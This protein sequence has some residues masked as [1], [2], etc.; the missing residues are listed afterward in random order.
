MSI[1]LNS[2]PSNIQKTY[3]SEALVHPYNT[4]VF[5]DYDTAVE[6]LMYKVLVPGEIAFAYYNDEACEYGINAIFAVG[7]IV[8]GCGNIIF[9]NALELQRIFDSLDTTI[10]D[11]NTSINRFNEDLKNMINDVSENLDQKLQDCI[12]SVMGP[13]NKYQEQ[14]NE[15]KEDTYNINVRLLDK[16]DTFDLEELSAKHDNDIN[17]LNALIETNHQDSLD[18]ISS[19]KTEV[20]EYIQEAIRSSLSQSDDKLDEVTNDNRNELQNA[21]KTIQN[22]YYNLF[23]DLSVSIKDLNKIHTDDVNILHTNINQLRREYD[24]LKSKYDILSEKYNN[25]II[26]LQNNLDDMRHRFLHHLTEYPD[27]FNKDFMG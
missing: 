23:N 6:M 14:I 17:D 18:K 11:V 10:A 3:P 25:D 15:L 27:D 4:K 24:I 8:H 9:Q 22:E 13:M 2:T 26:S 1:F 19:T 7:P 5:K 12:D 21:F 20:I 16:A